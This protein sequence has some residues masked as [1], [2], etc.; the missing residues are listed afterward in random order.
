MYIVCSHHM[1]NYQASAP[2]GKPYDKWAD[3]MIVPTTKETQYLLAASVI[4]KKVNSESSCYVT[5]I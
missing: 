3:D 2:A 5:N 4:E 1:I